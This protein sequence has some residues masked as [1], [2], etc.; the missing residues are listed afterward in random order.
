MSG[1]PNG[2]NG[3]DDPKSHGSI[4]SGIIRPQP[5]PAGPSGEQWYNRPQSVLR[6]PAQMAQDREPPRQ[7]LP[8]AEAQQKLQ[9]EGRVDAAGRLP[10]DIEDFV[11]TLSCMRAQ[12]IYEPHPGC[13]VYKKYLCRGGDPKLLMAFRGFD[14]PPSQTPPTAQPKNQ[15]PPP[16]PPSPP[17][18][19]FQK[20]PH[21]E[22]S[23]G[24]FGDLDSPSESL[25]AQQELLFDEFCNA[26]R[27]R[28]EQAAATPVSVYM[29]DQYSPPSPPQ[30]NPTP[31]KKPLGDIEFGFASPAPQRLD[32]QGQ[33]RQ[34]SQAEVEALLQK[35]KELEDKVEEAE[36]RCIELVQQTMC[37]CT[38]PNLC[39]CKSR[40]DGQ[41]GEP[42]DG[43][44]DEWP[45]LDEDGEVR[46]KP[47]LPPPSDTPKWD[48][49]KGKAVSHP[50][51][52]IHVTTEEP[53]PE[54]FFDEELFRQYVGRDPFHPS[55]FGEKVPPQQFSG[56]P[57][58]AAAFPP[59]Q[60]PPAQGPTYHVGMVNTETG[61]TPGASGSG[62]KPAF[63]TTFAY[64]NPNALAMASRAQVT[65][66]WD[67]Q[68]T[69]WSQ[70]RDS[71]VAFYPGLCPAPTH[72]LLQAFLSCLP[73]QEVQRWTRA[74]RTNPSLTW[75]T[76]CETLSRECA[77]DR[78][79]H[80][81][82]ELKRLRTCPQD[83]SGLRL[84]RSEFEDLVERQDDL[85]MG[86]VRKILLGKL[87]PK[88]H[89]LVLKQEN[90]LTRRSYPI[91]VSGVRV[92][93]DQIKALA[94]KQGKT[95]SKVVELNN[96]TRFN[97]PSK[98]DQD[99]WVQFLSDRS[100]TSKGR[101]VLLQ[102]TPSHVVLGPVQIFD[103]LSEHFRENLRQDEAKQA[104]QAL[105]Q[106]AEPQMVAETCEVHQARP[107]D[108]P[109]DDRQPKR[110]VYCWVCG[111]PDHTA[112]KCPKKATG[113]VKQQQQHGSTRK[114]ELELAQKPPQGLEVCFHCKRAER[115]CDHDY[116]A[117]E[118]LKQWRKENP[119]WF[120]NRQ[121]G[122]KGAAKP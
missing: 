59:Y 78:S 94:Q 9:D 60:M 80:K 20:T 100:F 22:D 51:K 85:S 6:S 23:E 49:G 68:I 116:K 111:S 104:H 107:R 37:P 15:A 58:A 71:W 17:A 113:P 18:T 25:K 117:C 89:D 11:G 87:H 74:L 84:W 115:S 5:A 112:G 121:K 29:T 114:A 16:K 36:V 72:V 46:K 42:S 70:F 106:P 91:K 99:Y 93:S 35:F 27:E 30:P 1:N 61:P 66:T 4:A 122:G 109:K 56:H 24:E 82:N 14:K 67:G 79:Q 34:W 48:K 55:D 53:Q 110:E 76:V 119:N 77:W 21:N 92:P 54:V 83:L 52:Q 19:P 43:G 26:A 90:K 120:Q 118:F 103:F 69:T 102:A 40:C 57:G 33:G 75:E 63:G 108:K 47:V 2:F 39:P 62:L 38:D 95:I 105:I 13:P 44:N 10:A 96:S 65:P 28:E 88:V 32:F 41:C 50:P 98:E 31:P 7:E 64:M 8:I 97:C 86:E 45:D 12:D 73:P 101:K 81:E 3:S